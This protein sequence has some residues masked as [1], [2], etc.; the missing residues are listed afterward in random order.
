[1]ITTSDGGMV[2]V[3]RGLAS[4]DR[5]RDYQLWLMRGS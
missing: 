1:M 4:I 3:A 2:F 5:N